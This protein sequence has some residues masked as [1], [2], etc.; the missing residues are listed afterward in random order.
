M[1]IFRNHGIS[2][3]HVYAGYIVTTHERV[4]VSLLFEFVLNLTFGTLLE[5]N[6]DFVCVCVSLSV[7]RFKIIFSFLLNC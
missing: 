5:Y 2:A 4:C 6:L 7:N 1:H 3:I